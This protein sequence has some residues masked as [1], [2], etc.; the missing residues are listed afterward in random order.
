MFGLFLKMSWAWKTNSCS[1]AP[2]WA[3][4]CTRGTHLKG[5]RSWQHVL[6]AYVL[7]DVGVVNICDCQGGRRPSVNCEIQCYFQYYSTKSWAILVVLHY[8]SQ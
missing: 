5:K 1:A 6:C 8:N 4:T 3:I 2:T 7:H